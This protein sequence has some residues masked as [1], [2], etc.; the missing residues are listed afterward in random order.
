M[1]SPS[2]PADRRVQTICLLILTL[3]GIGV[4]MELLRPVLVPFVLALFFVQCLNPIISLQVR[5]WHFPRWLAVTVATI[6][7]LALVTGAG[8]L[9]GASVGRMSESFPTYRAGLDK[10]I[11][12]AMASRP[13]HWFGIRSGATA[14]HILAIPAE[15]SISFV[16]LVLQET[17]NIVSHTATVLLLMAFLL[18]GQRPAH[19]PGIGILSEID[20]H[21]QRYI[22]LTVFISTLTGVMVGATLSIL[23]V[24]FAVAFGF[25]AFLLNFIPNIGAIIATILPLPVVLLGPHMSIVTQILAIA[26]P[27]AVQVSIGSLVQPKM[28]GNS[29]QLHPVVLLL[30]LLFF[31]MIWGVPGAFLATPVTAVIRIVFERIPLTRPL[32]A[33]LEGNLVPLTQTIETPPSATEVKVETDQ[34]WETTTMV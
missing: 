25:L 4:A 17:T 29:L 13:A 7:G 28:L 32:A 19:G 26:I 6:F 16:T 20:H 12:G 10:M 3:I 14:G 23:H 27:A 22:S 2:R 8:F 5:R 31:A 11:H 24:Q 33:L 15:A 30:S 34:D 18:F 21:V 1:R 9:I